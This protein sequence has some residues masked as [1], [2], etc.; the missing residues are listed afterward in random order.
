VTL[1]FIML[2]FGQWAKLIP[3]ACLAGILIV[4]AYNMSEWYS[5]VT[6][7]RGSKFDVLVLLVTFFLTVLVDLTFA[8]EIG[9]VLSS[10]LFMKRMAD[11]GSQAV[12]EVES[13]VLENYSDLPKELGI[14]EISGPFFFASAKQYRSTIRSIGTSSKVLILRMRHV[15]F[16]DSTGMHNL[17]D[18]VREIQHTGTKVVLSGVQPNVLKELERSNFY[19]LLAN[20]NV[21]P[22]FDQ[23]LKRA[24]VLLE[25]K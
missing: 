12:F 24:L 4:V 16:I 22:A 2:F 6:I 20:S 10:L 25:D 3:M 14:Y 17:K 18:V 19:E 23:A 11:A 15:P 21:L 1:L 7:L 5:F 9:I 13:D 8:I